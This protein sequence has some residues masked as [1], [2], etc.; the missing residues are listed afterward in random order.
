MRGVRYLTPEKR[1]SVED[2]KCKALRASGEKSKSGYPPPR[3]GHLAPN[4][5]STKVRSFNPSAVITFSYFNGLVR[6]RYF[7]S[8]F[9]LS[10]ICDKPNRLCLSFLWTFKCSVMYAILAVRAAIWTSDEPVSADHRAC[11]LRTRANSILLISALEAVS[12]PLNLRTISR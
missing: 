1:P 9:R 11:S 2:K 3:V 4:G 8:F 10:N 12:T 5:S 6:R 7:K